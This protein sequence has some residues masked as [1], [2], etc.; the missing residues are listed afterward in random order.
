MYNVGTNG[1]YWSSSPNAGNT[2]NAYNL[3]FSSGEVN[4]NNNNNRNNGYVA[5]SRPGGAQWFRQPRKLIG[6][7]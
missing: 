6:K 7:R 3:N 4:V 2:D 5:G 1:Y